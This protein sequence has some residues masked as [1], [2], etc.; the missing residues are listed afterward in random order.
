M[1]YKDFIN[2]KINDNFGIDERADYCDALDAVIDQIPDDCIYVF[3][4]TQFVIITDNLDKVVKIPFHGV[5]DFD[6]NED[7]SSIDGTYHF[8]PFEKVPDYCLRSIEIY[9]LA[10]IAGLS[11]IFAKTEYYTDTYSGYPLYLQ[12]KIETTYGNDQYERTPSQDSLNKT[13]SIKESRKFPKDWFA[14]VIDQY[15]LDF[16]IKFL[17]FCNKNIK[18]LHEENIGYRKDGSAVVIDYASYLD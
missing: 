1:D 10:E 2:L 4:A 9:D 8:I 15:G 16:A 12:E 7:G 18:D 5:W 13:D 3:G 11:S 17:A 6:Y 14:S